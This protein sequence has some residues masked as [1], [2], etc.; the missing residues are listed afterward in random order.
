MAKRKRYTREFKEEAAKLVIEQGYKQSVASKNLGVTAKNISRWVHDAK[1]LPVKKS[2]QAPDGAE[3]ARLKKE[4]HQLRL[5]REILKK[6][7]A[8]FANEPS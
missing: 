5:E 3:L 6:A 8:F 4:N 7:A 1:G 2:V